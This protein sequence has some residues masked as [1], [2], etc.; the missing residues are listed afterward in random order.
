[1]SEI[2]DETEF[3]GVGEGRKKGGVADKELEKAGS[4][5]FDPH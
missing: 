2:G 1:L 4:K 5:S 3:S